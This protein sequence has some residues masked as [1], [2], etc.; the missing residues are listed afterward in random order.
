MKKEL[1]I[2]TY[3]GYANENRFYVKGRVLR[4]PRIE[5]LE[6]QSKFRTFYN[7]LKRFNS[8]EV[9]GANLKVTV[10]NQTFELS[11]DEE[12]Y[13]A[14]EGT[15]KQTFLPAPNNHTWIP[16]KVEAMDYQTYEV[17]KILVP[18]QDK[19]YGVISD[20]D[21]T[22]LQTFATSRLRL[23]ML[24]ATFFLNPYRRLPMEGIQEVYQQLDRKGK[25]RNQKPVFYV[26]NSNWNINDSIL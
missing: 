11:T 3:Y 19:L 20:V 15:S 2:Q 18:S 24:Y 23:K 8:D 16:Y 1:S 21:D 7:N 25:F 13:F 22:V 5:I 4:D 17:G 10:L 9:K 12:G 14:L 6:G 26:S